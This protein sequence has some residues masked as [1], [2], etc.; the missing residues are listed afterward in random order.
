[1]NELSLKYGSKGLSVVGF[2]CNQFGHQENCGEK[3]ILNSLKYVRP[4]NGFEPEFDMMA[5]VTVNGVDAHPLY[6]YLKREVPFPS[7]DHVSFMSEN[8]YVIWN[9]V[10]RSDI[11]WNFEK[12]LIGANGVPVKRYS[13]KFQMRDMTA[14][15]EE[16]L[17]KI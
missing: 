5:K 10:E 16:Q 15:I 4:G 9:P 7:D 14:D 13:K 11:A 17:S 8:H 12:F 2:P 1:M 3:E 6:K